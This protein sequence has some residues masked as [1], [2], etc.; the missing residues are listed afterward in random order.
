MAGV[1]HPA[2]FAAVAPECT[3]KI[4]TFKAQ[5]LANVAFA[6]ATARVKAPELFAAIAVEAPKRAFYDNTAKDNLLWAFSMAD[7]AAP[8]LEAQTLAR[9]AQT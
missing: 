1:D 6:F 4:T 5:E 3:R 8:N 9:P 7:V 2:L